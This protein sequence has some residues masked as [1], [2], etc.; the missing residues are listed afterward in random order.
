MQEEWHF[1]MFPGGQVHLNAFK[2]ICLESIFGN[3]HVTIYLQIHHISPLDVVDI[4]GSIHEAIL[5]T[6]NKV[7]DVCVYMY[8]IVCVYDCEYEH[9]N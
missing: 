8:A 7:C 9:V 1:D 6:Q 3:I 5:I 4:N 2:S